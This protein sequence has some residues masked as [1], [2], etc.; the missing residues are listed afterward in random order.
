MQSIVTHRALLSQ[1]DTQLRSYGCPSAG[2]FSLARF[3]TKQQTEQLGSMTRINYPE[4]RPREDHGR[5]SK[6]FKHH[7]VFIYL[8]QPPLPAPTREAPSTATT[9]G[10]LA[11]LGRGYC[12][13]W[14]EML[15]LM[16]KARLGSTRS[17]Q[18]GRRS[19]RGT[20]M[21]H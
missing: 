5:S 21:L 18:T 16:P 15:N 6:V 13:F 11:D 4:M 10:A 8:F 7:R 12:R 2:A 3:T 17:F 1:E 19:Q 14:M 20:D 9:R